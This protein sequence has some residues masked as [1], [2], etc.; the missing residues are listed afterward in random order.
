MLTLFPTTMKTILENMQY[1]SKR[2]TIENSREVISRLKFISM[3][4]RD[5]KINV[6]TLYIQP[7]NMLTSLQRLFQQESRDS[8]KNFLNT[9]YNRI[10]EILTL[11]SC[12]DDRESDKTV[13]LNLVKDL[14]MSVSGLENLQYTYSDDRMFV[15]EINTLIEDIHRN[16]RIIRKKKPHFFMEETTTSELS[17]QEPTN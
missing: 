14:H 6:K 16:I 1:E 10:F 17:E 13:I 15:S 8:T 2:G 5:E 7:K 3:I 4:K 12:S 11:Y 9:T